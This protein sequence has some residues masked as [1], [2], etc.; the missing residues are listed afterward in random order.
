MKKML[1]SII[2]L[3]LAV[4][5]SSCN[6]CL[7][8]GFF[9]GPDVCGF[10]SF[11]T[12]LDN[13]LYSSPVAPPPPPNETRTPLPPQQIV[14]DPISSEP[15]GGGQE[16]D[17]PSSFKEIITAPS[18]TLGPSLSWLGGDKD[19]GEKFPARPGFQLG[20]S[21]QVPLTN[22]LNFEPGLSYAN[23]GV[24]YES[25]ESGYEVPGDGP[26][27]SYSYSYGQKK[28]LHYLELPLFVS[29][30]VLDGLDLYGGP[31]VAFLLGAKMVNESNGE[32]TSTEKGTDGL[33][34]VDLGI[35]AGAR[36]QIPNTF[37][38]VSLG[39][40]QGLSNLN[41][42]S[43][44]AGYGY[45]EPKYRTRAAR[46]GVQYNFPAARN[47]ARSGSGKKSEFRSWISK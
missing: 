46:L 18:F 36:Y 4:S 12:S 27:G 17:R 41:S 20:A 35:S 33:N 32:T 5:L 31:Q 42:K 21:W 6:P 13:A 44:Y 25:E 11:I 37:F 23:R 8:F 38:S 16:N 15:G 24:G 22:R 1:T 7:F 2:S 40:Y 45:E 39:Y 19:E 10:G 14:G 43:E 3:S 30:S 47:N 29:G 28:T 34:K 26:G 9:L